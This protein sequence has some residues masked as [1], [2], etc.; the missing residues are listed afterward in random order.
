M[1]LMGNGALVGSQS[2][3]AE[4]QLNPPWRAVRDESEYWELFVE[5]EKPNFHTANLRF[6]TLKI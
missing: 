5:L 2:N 1:R 6:N 3:F 4:A